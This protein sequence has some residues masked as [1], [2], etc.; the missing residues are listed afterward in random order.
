MSILISLISGGAAMLAS[1]WF[2]AKLVPEPKNSVPIPHPEP[3]SLW[4]PGSTAFW[5]DP[6]LWNRTPEIDDRLDICWMHLDGPILR[7]E[8]VAGRPLQVMW[9]TLRREMQVQTVWT[10][11]YGKHHLPPPVDGVRL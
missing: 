4:E 8:A 10:D 9:G 3:P 2:A 5:L 7:R 11:I 1:S 6:D